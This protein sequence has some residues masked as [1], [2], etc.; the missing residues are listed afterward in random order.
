MLSAIATGI[1]TSV[2]VVDRATAGSLLHLN[3]R[4]HPP[5][6]ID[7]MPFG[8]VVAAAVLLLVAAM[9]PTD[10]DGP[11]WERWRHLPG[12]FDVVGP[13]SDGQLIVAG[14]GRLFLVNAAGTV[15]PFARGRT[16]YADD[17]G[18]E[19]YL[20]VSPGLHVA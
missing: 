1:S 15:V 11:G 18:T 16:G 5:T 12:V 19:A 3:S 13:R 6:N 17:A 20:T 7:S 2:R 4:S 14:S 9:T 8:R 10:A